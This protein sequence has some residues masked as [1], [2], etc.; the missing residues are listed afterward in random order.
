MG[1]D[2]VWCGGGLLVYTCVYARG[3]RCFVPAAG[4]WRRGRQR[5]SRRRRRPRRPHRM[6]K[7]KRRRR[8]ALCACVVCAMGRFDRP[9]DRSIDQG[10]MPTP[11]VDTSKPC[12]HACLP[13]RPAPNSPAA[14]TSAGR[15][16]LP[17]FRRRED[18]DHA[19]LSLL[20][21]YCMCVYVCVLSGG[22]SRQQHTRAHAIAKAAVVRELV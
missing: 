12:M 16:C 18:R 2:S 9:T 5:R 15:R 20:P 6:M 14:A 13:R 22:R 3:C 7:R 1:I 8:R 11:Q 10:G 21:A 4:A 17:Q 19:I